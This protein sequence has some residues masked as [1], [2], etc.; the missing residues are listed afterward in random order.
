MERKRIT[1]LLVQNSA[2][3]TVREKQQL[4]SYGYRV[5]QVQGNEKILHT[6]AE[7]SEPVHLILIDMD[8]FSEAQ[9][10]ELAEHL[11]S[12]LSLPL[13]WISSHVEKDFVA[14]TKH[15]EAYGFVD[16]QSGIAV[17][18]AAIQVALK[19][20]HAKQKEMRIEQELLDRNQKLQKLLESLPYPGWLIDRDKTIVSQN[21][22]AEELFHSQSGKLCWAAIHDG[23]W[24]KPAQY[25]EYKETGA[26][27]PNA[28]C[29]FCRA[30]EALENQKPVTDIVE[31]DRH[32]YKVWWIPISRDLFLDFVEDVTDL[33]RAELRLA[34][35]I[36]GTQ[37]ATWEWNVQSGETIINERWA[38]MVGY[39]LDELS[40]TSID[41][42]NNF[43]HPEDRDK[44]EHALEK[45]FSGEL[46]YYEAEV[47]LRHKNG[48][49]VWI[50]DRG[51]VT[52]WTSD[53]KPLIMMGT[54][55]DITYLKN[56]SEKLQKELLVKETL[57]REVHHRVKN[58]LATLETLLSFQAEGTDNPEVRQGLQ[59]AIA[60]TASMQ[61][62][63]EKLLVTDNYSEISV[64][65]YL[66]DLADSILSVFVLPHY[67]TIEIEIADFLLNSKK[68]VPLGLIFNELLTNVLKYAFAG[69][70]KGKISINMEKQEAATILRIKDTGIGIDEQ[71]LKNGSAGFGLT[72][73]KMLAE[74]L[75]GTFTIKVDRGTESILRFPI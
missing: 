22:K 1:I 65:N 29:R 10:I 23:K 63:Y 74:E 18:D 43:L 3:P 12:S 71:I 72:I 17:L 50:L 60:R 16:K 28:A 42:W 19:L 21:K 38:E 11:V 73:V 57:L 61:T 32:F 66:E 41:T 13:I 69:F 9:G 59:N 8:S 51:K 24:L 20:F 25:G 46:P 68:I 48:S 53:G 39:T 47:R 52:E 45:H 27:P 31:M 62:L 30:A 7:S 64:K 56:I 6:L 55:Q 75:K 33:K 37:T 58:N 67:I 26:C 54:H 36:E 4:E 44:S 5:L 2:P 14:K 70:E 34:S 40:P 35:I 15:I 49:W